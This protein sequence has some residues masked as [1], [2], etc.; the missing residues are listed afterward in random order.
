MKPPLSVPDAVATTTIRSPSI[1]K[2][3]VAKVTSGNPLIHA[4]WISSTACKPRIVP[5]AVGLSTTQS[6]AKHCVQRGADQI[7]HLVN[8]NGLFTT[9]RPEIEPHQLVRITTIRRVVESSLL[10]KECARILH[11]GV[12]CSGGEGRIA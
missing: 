5:P 7:D 8:S 9:K 10:S 6:G 4:R 11:G 3:S 2:P 1:S 12:E